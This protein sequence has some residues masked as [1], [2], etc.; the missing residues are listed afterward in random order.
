MGRPV[1]RAW[2]LGIVLV[3]VLAGAATSVLAKGGGGTP[4]PKAQEKTLCWTCH[5]SYNP[6]LKHFTYV[7]PPGKADFPSKLSNPIFKEAPV[8][9]WPIRVNNGYGRPTDPYKNDITHAIITVDLRNAPSLKF[10]A[11][12]APIKDQLLAGLIPNSPPT[13]VPQVPTIPPSATPPSTTFH[14]TV[15]NITI[16]PGATKVGLCLEAGP[17]PGPVY[18]MRVFAG[19]DTKPRL[20]Y[21]ASAPAQEL[22]ISDADGAAL[23]SGNFSVEASYQWPDARSP[24]YVPFTSPTTP[25]QVK[26]NVDFGSSGQVQQQAT[27]ETIPA[28]GNKL[29]NFRLANVQ[30]PGAS[31][32]VRITV[33][34]T[35]Y[36]LHKTANGAIDWENIT[37]ELVIPVASDD[38]QGGSLLQIQGGIVVKP[39]VQNGATAS[40]ISE[41]VGYASAFLLIGSNWSGGVFGQRSRQQL[42]RFFA[43]A[44][45]RVAFHNFVSYG[46]TAAA[47]AHMLIFLLRLSRDYQITLGLIWG[48]IAILAMFALGVTGALQIPMIRRWGYGNWQQVH[49]WL[50]IASVA[51]TVIHLLLDGANFTFVQEALHWHD[52]F[53]PAQ[54]GGFR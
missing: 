13:G 52:P 31:E 7:I 2:R 25:F 44:R 50:G 53:A 47:L 18:T 26:L 28:L 15:S 37:T 39:N 42:N 21:N 45:R 30:A 8:K 3:L 1:G 5:A 10:G 48:G 41:A 22:C 51:F 4:D 49:F 11:A 16:G 34:T 12:P 36:H 46:L 23:G 6:P 38:N 54:G 33:N 43:T 24:S 20:V 32:S 35:V 40:R 14:G 17:D 27:S 29:F 9:D 19:N